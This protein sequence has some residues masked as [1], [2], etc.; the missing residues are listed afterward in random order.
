MADRV[1]VM[2]EGRTVQVAD[3]R[4]LYGAPRTEFVASFVGEA[5]G[6]EAEVSKVGDDG[7]EARTGTGRISVAHRPEGVEKGQRVRLLVRPEDILVGH[8]LGG[9]NILE[10]RT[11]DVAFFGGS[12]E[13]TV[14][15]RGAVRLRVVRQTRATEPVRPGDAV[16]ISIPPEAVRVFVWGG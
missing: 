12:E 10:G 14:E 11:T 8:G 6:L 5:N 2:S 7:L 9:E 16:E 13:L 15:L 1:A 4:G 3:P